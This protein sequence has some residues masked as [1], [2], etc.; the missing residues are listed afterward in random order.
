MTI[1]NKAQAVQIIDAL[2]CPYTPHY[3]HEL[4]R[5]TLN[6]GEIYAL[7]LA[8]AEYGFHDPITRYSDYMEQRVLFAGVPYFFGGC[9]KIFLDKTEGDE[10]ESLDSQVISI[11]EQAP[12]A[13]TASLAVSTLRYGLTAQQVLM[14]GDQDFERMKLVMLYFVSNALSPFRNEILSSQGRFSRC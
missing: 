14:C 2:G 6:N 9:K 7:D 1:H 12:Q 13:I 11:K 5:V 3:T 10:D 4:L 8:G